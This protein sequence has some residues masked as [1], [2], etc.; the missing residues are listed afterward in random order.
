M[1]TKKI[2]KKVGKC[3]GKNVPAKHN[4]KYV[5]ETVTS[6]NTSVVEEK[7]DDVPIPEVLEAVTTKKGAP[8]D[9][10]GD[11][12]VGGHTP[13]LCRKYARGPHGVG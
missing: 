6:S 12:V 1:V 10:V 5:V 11:D 3:A 8:P 4:P 2:P 9:K 7:T 13:Q